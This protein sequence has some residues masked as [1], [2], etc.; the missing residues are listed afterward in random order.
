MSRENHIA[1]TF[2]E[3]ADTLVEDF[4][5]IDFLQ[6]MTVRCRELLDVTDAAVFLAHPGPDL[7]SP[8]PCDA[9]P[10]LQRTLDAACG[11][12]PATEAHRTAR[13]VDTRSTAEAAA[14]WP[15]FTSR[16]QQAG[17]TL[18][19]GLPMRLRRDNI[20]SLLLLRT[21]DQPLNADDLALAQALADAATIGLLQAR[22]IDQQ[23]TINGQLHNALQNRIVIEQAK[24]ILAARRDISLTQAF[25]SL[26]RHARN[27]QTLLSEVAHDVIDNGFTPAIVR[28]RINSADSE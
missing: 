27:H 28:P 18:A 21:G 4:D 22:T 6:Q 10:A 12:G 8:A 11:Q 19:T 5:V 3:L 1:R 24:G 15:E 17:Y 20:G 16:L 26:R 14:R 23:H 9:G 2:L 13:V 7:H 25:D